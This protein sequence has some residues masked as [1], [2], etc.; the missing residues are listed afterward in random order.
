MNISSKNHYEVLGVSPDASDEEIKHAFHNFAKNNHPD[1]NPQNSDSEQL[2]KEAAL[3]YE[4]LKD[5][6]RRQAF[7]EA[8]A[9]ERKNRRAGQRQGRRLMLL[10]GLLLVAPSAI[11]MS[12]FVSGD[13]YVLSKLG[14]LP[15]AAST[16]QTDA[17]D[18]NAITGN[19]S[20]E[21]GIVADSNSAPVRQQGNDVITNTSS[22][23]SDTVQDELARSAAAPRTSLPDHIGAVAKQT[24]NQSVPVSPEEFASLSRT[25]PPVEV[26]AQSPIPEVK[27]EELQ[28]P[29]IIVSADVDVSG[30]FSDCNICPLMFVPKRSIAGIEGTGNAISMAEITIAQ[31]E[32]CTKD[33]ACPEYDQKKARKIEPVTG[34]DKEAAEI[35]AS[36]LTRVTGQ[37]YMAV[38]PKET[39]DC[40]FKAN[41]FAANRWDWMR[42]SSGGGCPSPG[43]FRVS[44]Q[45]KTGS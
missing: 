35:Y 30:P 5:P 44:R 16:I 40:K 45:I 4:T 10:F 42:P 6:L 24:A 8:V 11:F 36:W 17:D 34:M 33:G 20:Q 23:L 25:D 7:D 9:F 1:R 43:G 28:P 14:F 37:S 41:R 38:L 27:V 32:N 29:K 19:H 12:F 39:P 26:A 18:T 2:F 13:K 21:T 22:V 3:A 31:W 15:Q